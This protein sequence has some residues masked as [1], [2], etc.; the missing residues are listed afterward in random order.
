MR[1]TKLRT[2]VSLPPRRK[3]CAAPGS[4]GGTAGHTDPSARMPTGPIGSWSVALSLPGSSA[5]VPAGGIAV[6]VLVT[7]APTATRR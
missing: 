5:V 4:V 6:T 7:K 3:L 1:G 2:S